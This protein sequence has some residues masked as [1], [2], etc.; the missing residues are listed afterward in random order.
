MLL[1]APL[2]NQSSGANQSSHIVLTSDNLQTDCERIAKNGSRV[3][4]PPKRAG[5]GNAI[6]THIADPDGN[7]YQPV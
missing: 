5:W 1:K 2:Q 7:I 6:E 3:I 4:Y